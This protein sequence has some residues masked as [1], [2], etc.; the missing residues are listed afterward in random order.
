MGLSIRTS[1]EPGRAD[2][3]IPELWSRF[4]SASGAAAIPGATGPDVYCVYTEYEGDHTLPY[5]VV[6]G[7][8]VDNIDTVPEGCRGIAIPG[9]P[10]QRVTVKGNL[11]DSIV[12]DAW[13]GIWQSG[14]D[15]AYTADYEVYAPGASKDGSAEVNIFI[16]VKE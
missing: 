16:A 15:R 3:D 11:D 13:L 4:L 2:K 14:W 6:L 1:N 7:Y 8:A 10:Y 12:Y 9:G 5:T